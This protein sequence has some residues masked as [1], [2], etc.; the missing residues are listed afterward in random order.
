MVEVNKRGD[1]YRDAYAR[2][3]PALTVICFL[4][5]LAAVVVTVQTEMSGTGVDA[6]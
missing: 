1:Q 3:P 6:T 4:A 5:V 2:Q